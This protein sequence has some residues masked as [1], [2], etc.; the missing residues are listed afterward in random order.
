L[1]GQV[2]PATTIFS[3][4]LLLFT[5]ASMTPVAA[6]LARPIVVVPMSATTSAMTIPGLLLRS[7]RT[8]DFSDP[9]TPALPK[10]GLSAQRPLASRRTVRVGLSMDCVWLMSIARGRVGSKELD[11]I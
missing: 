5:H 7:P 9:M 11:A 3:S 2:E 6:A 1:F 4:P 8:S 10:G